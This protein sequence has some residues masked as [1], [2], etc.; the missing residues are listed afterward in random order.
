M[1]MPMLKNLTTIRRPHAALFR[2]DLED[3]QH[4]PRTFAE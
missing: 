1:P 2:D 3:R 4:V